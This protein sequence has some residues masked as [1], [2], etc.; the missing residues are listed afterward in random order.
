MTFF[1]TSKTSVFSIF[2]E[3][4]H[5]FDVINIAIVQVIFQENLKN[6]FVIKKILNQKS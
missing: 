5:N 4:S 2:E 6:N 3:I 1:K